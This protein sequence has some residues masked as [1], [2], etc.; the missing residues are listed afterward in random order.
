MG[1][2][3]TAE[4][5]R[6][7]WLY[8]PYRIAIG[9]VDSE[10]KHRLQQFLRIACIVTP[11][12][13]AITSHSFAP[14]QFRHCIAQLDFTVRHDIVSVVMLQDVKQERCEQID[15]EITEV[16]LRRKSFHAQ[17]FPRNVYRRFFGDV[18]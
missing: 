12:R 9:P 10:S 11:P 15:A 17:C 16:S 18:S 1:G 2:C 5:K 13:N 6:R 7:R 3:S 4:T 14:N 8:P